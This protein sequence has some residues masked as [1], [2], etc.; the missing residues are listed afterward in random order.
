M[1]NYTCGIR[2]RFDSSKYHESTFNLAL[3]EEDII[4]I[5]TFLKENGDQPF[6]AF[7]YENEGLFNRMMEAHVAAI[8]E[9]VNRVILIPGDEPY[10]EETV[11]WECLFPEFLWPESLM[12][13]LGK[14]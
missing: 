9:Y 12:D 7:E 8:L 14:E 5:K 3:N 11:D 1:Q 4:F 2:F 6:W 10:S 13:S